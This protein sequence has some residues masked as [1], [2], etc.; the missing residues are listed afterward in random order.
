M[1]PAYY[2]GAIAGSSREGQSI[3]PDALGM[4]DILCP[5]VSIQN[6]FYDWLV[7]HSHRAATLDKE[8]RHLVSQRDMLMPQLVSGELR[9]REVIHGGL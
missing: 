8:T 2:Y 9:V 6:A 3:S 1:N 5:P 7:P 4:L